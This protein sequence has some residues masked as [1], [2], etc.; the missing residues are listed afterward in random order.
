[1]SRHHEAKSF[2]AASP[3]EIF[4]RLD[5]QTRL[6]EHMGKS[7]AMMGGGKMTY[8]FDGGG[9]RA[10]GSHI[11]MGGKA[12]GLKLFVDEVVTERDPPRRKVWKTVGAPR[13]LVVGGYAMGFEITPAVG[14]SWLKVWIDYD[15]PKTAVGAAAGPLLA[16]MYAR[17]CVE[18][19]VSDAVAHFAPTAAA[20]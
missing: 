17:W 3:A 8:D 2:V 13:L 5:D 10:V 14:G 12:F 18:R 9:G 15:L 4:A 7:S 20:A 11:R 16:P 19:M 1:M 6:G